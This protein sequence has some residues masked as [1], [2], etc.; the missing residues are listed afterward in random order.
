MQVVICFHCNVINASPDSLQLKLPD[1]LRELFHDVS[2]TNNDALHY[3]PTLSLDLIIRNHGCE[4]SNRNLSAR[5]AHSQYQTGPHGI[6]FPLQ[7]V[8]IHT[9]L[10]NQKCVKS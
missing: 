10:W 3:C 2:A 7:S 9:F 6:I 4:I 1:D 5:V 8:Q